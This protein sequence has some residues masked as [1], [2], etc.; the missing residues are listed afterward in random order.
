M[1]FSEQIDNHG[2]NNTLPSKGKL[3]SKIE[4]SL[5]VKHGNIFYL[6]WGEKK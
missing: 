2:W 3:T 4:I 5:T 6:A 1:I